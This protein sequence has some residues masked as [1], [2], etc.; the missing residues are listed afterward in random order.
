MYSVPVTRGN[1][2][3]MLLLCALFTT[4]FSKAQ[5]IASGPNSPGTS[6]NVDFGGYSFADPL[7]S[8]LSDNNRS[9][10]YS[11]LSLGHTDYLQATNFG[12]SIPTAATICGIEVNIEKSAI[13]LLLTAYI[14]DN[15]VRIIKNGSP[16]GDN[17]ALN[18]VWPE[19]VDANSTYG[20][21]NDLWGTAWT[22]ADI[23]STDF[24]VAIS[25][26]I[27]GLIGVF[28]A[29]R[30]NHISMTVYYLDPSVLPA[31]TLQF[32]VAK[33]S[34]QTAVLSWKA[35][36]TSETETVFIERSANGTKWKTLT[37]T[38]QKNNLMSLYTFTD[39]HPLAGKSLYRL[40]IK[41]ASG[42]IRYTT[43]Q[44]FEQRDHT[45]IKCYPNPFTSFVQVT[46]IMA[47][48]QVTLTDLYGKRLSLPV[49]AV[50]NTVKIDVSHL[51][52]GI[53][54]IGTSNRKMKIQKK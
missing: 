49:T 11:L 39:L 37:G 8:L 5:C 40:K 31:Q 48:E 41:T 16:D 24:G 42:G 27:R 10:A 18:A 9:I 33:G 30:I 46:G 25:A 38:A 23:N 28:P 45:S 7:N 43:T 51:Q 54:V 44:P 22:P 36:T 4:R 6:A 34:N 17:M 15:S 52:P 50:H 12:F 29:A 26:Q 13:D 19:D 2:V 1:K 20:N 32:K 35:N 14:R 53:Y 47:G 3:A 21:T